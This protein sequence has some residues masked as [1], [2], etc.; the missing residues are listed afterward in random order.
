MRSHSKSDPSAII[1][2]HKRRQ[3]ALYGLETKDDAR[4]TQTLMPHLSERET[5]SPAS[6]QS[7]D[8][9]SPGSR[10]KKII[11]RLDLRK[12]S[13]SPKDVPPSR[14]HPQRPSSKRKSVDAPT[15]ISKEHM[16]QTTL[17]ADSWSAG[18]TDQQAL[19]A[20]PSTEA[21]SVVPPHLYQTQ[22]PTGR[23]ALNGMGSATVSESEIP[24]ASSEQTL[25]EDNAVGDKDHGYGDS[26]NNID[27]LDTSA[28]EKR[29]QSPS[30]SS[31]EPV[32][33]KRTR[34]S[35]LDTPQKRKVT[36]EGIKVRQGPVVKRRRSLKQL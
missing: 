6:A 29:R 35:Q 25:K 36:Q 19:S 30:G 13:A 18:K 33:R 7:L 28:A 16:T 1:P 24:A 4:P 10:S 15:D 11:V 20:L 26:L 27:S 21:V 22:E 14:K 2:Q 8:E 34:N 32:S 5:N 23:G 31:P 12:L 3:S 17:S 9:H